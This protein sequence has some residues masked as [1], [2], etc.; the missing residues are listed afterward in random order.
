MAE[1]S[2]RPAVY[3]PLSLVIENLIHSRPLSSPSLILCIILLTLEGRTRGDP[4]AGRGD[5]GLHPRLRA[6]HRHPA[7]CRSISRPF[8]SFYYPYILIFTC[9]V[10][11]WCILPQSLLAGSADAL[12]FG[13]SHRRGHD[14]THSRLRQNVTSAT[15]TKRLTPNA[16]HEVTASRKRSKWRPATRWSSLVRTA[17][18]S[19]SP[20]RRRRRLKK[21]TGNRCS[22]YPS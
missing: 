9:L 15:G 16:F 3:Q 14:A 8:P 1:S 10:I 4:G 5:H 2:P 17:A 6:D 7:A 18:S 20:R 12:A 19:L 11:S 13:L 21:T 22:R